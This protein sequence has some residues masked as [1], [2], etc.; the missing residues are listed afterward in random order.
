MKKA[1]FVGFLLV[2]LLAT[3]C[4][5]QMVFTRAGKAHGGT[6]SAWVRITPLPQYADWWKKNE[7]CLTQIIAL[8]LPDPV[9]MPQPLAPFDSLKW[10]VAGDSMFVNHRG[11]AMFGQVFPP[12][13]VVLAGL[14][15]QRE[16]LVR[17]ELLHVRGFIG[18]PMVPF[19]NPCGVP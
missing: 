14:L 9:D 10:Y 4:E 3:A 5:G 12:D 15:M 6:P 17:H 2:V 19:V 16:K 8:D 1:F 18:H 11:S 7:V 13:T